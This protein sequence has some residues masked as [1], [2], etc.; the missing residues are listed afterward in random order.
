MIFSKFK[1]LF[2]FHDSHWQNPEK[3]NNLKQ[4]IYSLLKRIIIPDQKNS[5]VKFELTSTFLMPDLKRYFQ[6]QLH[7]QG[8]LFQAAGWHHRNK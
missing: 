3:S 2:Q 7:F 8:V 6:R 5:I 1:K 4:S